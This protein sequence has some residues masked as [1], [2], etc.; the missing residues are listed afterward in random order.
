MQPV[1][2][3][4][5]RPTR[6]TL[7]GMCR[8]FVDELAGSE[9]VDYV[10]LWVRDGYLHRDPG[11][12]YELVK[13]VPEGRTA[14]VIDADHETAEWARSVGAFGWMA[15]D[16][17]PSGLLSRR[18]AAGVFVLFAQEHHLILALNLR[19]ENAEVDGV[20]LKLAELS[21]KLTSRFE[22][23]EDVPDLGPIT[24]DVK[25]LEAM[26]MGD[27]TFVRHMLD[28]CITELS[29]GSEKLFEALIHETAGDVV[30]HAHK[31][32][33]TAR[34]AGAERL[35]ALLEEIEQAAE[36]GDLSRVRMGVRGCERAISAINK[37][38]AAR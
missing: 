14:R 19:D 22:L 1:S 10:A 27:P 35:D 18:G 21:S 26:A 28:L 11:E 36:Q 23:I 37:I 9:G 13:A 15:C 31:L 32:R 2:K 7:R 6:S 34:T 4:E 3:E 30:Y 12:G 16:Q 20:Q 8:A 29:A 24:V 25:F 33:S 17:P 38:L 5:L